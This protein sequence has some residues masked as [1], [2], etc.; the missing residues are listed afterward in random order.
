MA[1]KPKSTTPEPTPAP[2]TER[3]NKISD[4]LDLM[5]WV[6]V[7][8][9][10][11]GGAAA[12]IAVAAA[13]YWFY[14]RSQQ[15]KT[16]N[17]DRSLM[18]AEQSL[19]SGNAALASSDLQR[20]VTRYKGTGAGTE[21]ALLLAQADYN[22]GKYPDG[23]KVLQE[24]SGKAG[25]SEGMVQSLIGDGHAQMGK[26]ADAAKAYEKAA[27]ASIYENEKAY[28]RAKAARSYSAA[29][30]AADARRLWTQLSTDAKSQSVAAEARVRLAELD[31]KRAGKS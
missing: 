26:N 2:S 3:A 12:V 1:A 30:N 16:I 13:G 7:N 19:Q 10:L 14:I 23:I 21:A 20:V 5:E 4:G 9:R 22:G 28:Y 31:A 6:Q 25:G 8:S 18:Q 24:V 27:D 17:A 11:L 29:G 15:I